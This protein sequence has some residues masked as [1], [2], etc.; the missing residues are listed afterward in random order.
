[1][2][3][4]RKQPD[5]NDVWHVTGC[6]PLPWPQ[7]RRIPLEGLPYDGDLELVEFAREE[8]RNTDLTG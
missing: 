8:M 1:V 2:F 7:C 5:E 3:A 6:L 4:I